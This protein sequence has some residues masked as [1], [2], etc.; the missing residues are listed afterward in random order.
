MS[1]TANTSSPGDPSLSVMIFSPEY[2]PNAVGGLGTH[3]F[4]LATGLGCAGCRVNILTPTLEASSRHTAGNV[5]VHQISMSNI[6]YDSSRTGMEKFFQVCHN[7]ALLYGKTLIS[8]YGYGPDL[9]HCHDWTSFSAAYQLGQM[10]KIP[11]VGTVHLL[12]KPLRRWWG[13][14]IF[15]ESVRKEE[16]LCRQ[17]DTLITVS[18]LMR[19][20]ICDTYSVPADQIQVVYNGFDAEPFL[21]PLLSS[22]ETSEFR[23]AFA[24]PGEKIVLYAGRLSLQKGLDALMASASQVVA[25]K[26]GV[27]FIMAGGDQTMSAA[28]ITR[29]TQEMYPQYAT[30]WNNFKFLGKVPR[31]YITKLYQVADIAVVPSIYEPFGYA[32]IE[33]MAAGVPVVATNVGGL[34]EIIAHG[35]TGLLVPVHP[36]PQG[37]YKVDAEKLSEA[38][39]R[40]LND[41]TLAKRMAKAG[42]QHV[43]REFSL[44]RMIQSTTQV[45]R[46]AITNYAKSGQPKARYFVTNA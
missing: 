14:P 9:I 13:E 33:A 42:Q 35:Q 19:E 4:E 15:D 21:K 20:I 24:A 39:M 7:R 22:Q 34:A 17:S 1:T 8:R 10:F 46:Q 18:Q 45:Y 23:R 37:L 28:Q 27:R 30:L 3:V 16:S 25:K 36:S 5:T 2:P 43:L 29:E 38:L 12:Y 26:T 6:P 40:L 44:Q 32:A 41:E 11:V 31:D